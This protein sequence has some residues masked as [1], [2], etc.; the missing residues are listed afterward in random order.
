MKL[1]RAVISIFVSCIFFGFTLTVEGAVTS[2]S[3]R[4]S[5]ENDVGLFDTIDFNGLTDTSYLVPS[6]NHSIDDVTLVLLDLGVYIG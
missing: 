5:W 3:D 6:G 4:A 1:S 2:Y